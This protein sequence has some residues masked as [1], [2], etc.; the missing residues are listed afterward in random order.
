MNPKFE[1]KIVFD[2]VRFILKIR[3]RF[4]IPGV[5][6]QKNNLGSFSENCV[7]RSLYKEDT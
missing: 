5:K 4:E 3:L 2:R 1:N 7:S 6:P